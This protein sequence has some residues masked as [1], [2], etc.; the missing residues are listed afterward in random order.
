MLGL[1]VVL[2]VTLSSTF[3]RAPLLPASEAGLIAGSPEYKTEESA[4]V[5]KTAPFTSLFHLTS[6]SLISLTS[7]SS[8]VTNSG[9]SS[10]YQESK[11]KHVRIHTKNFIKTHR[12]VMGWMKLLYLIIYGTGKFSSNIVSYLVFFLFILFLFNFFFIQ[13]I[14]KS[15]A[16]NVV[17]I[18]ILSTNKKLKFGSH[19]SENA[20]QKSEL[21]SQTSYFENEILVFSQFFY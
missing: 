8:S 15:T 21:A 13:N 1:P 2:P 4:R 6:M 16:R 5:L 14:F 17:N 11:N 19:Q 9:S 10:C 18:S 7:T 20:F 12:K 3:S